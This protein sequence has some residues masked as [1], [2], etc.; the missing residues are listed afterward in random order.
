MTCKEM[1]AKTYVALQE[2]KRAKIR[3]AKEK[4]NLG[5]VLAVE[6]AKRHR[7]RKNLKYFY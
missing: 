6:S 2:R 3:L 1:A 5:V 7:G 4:E